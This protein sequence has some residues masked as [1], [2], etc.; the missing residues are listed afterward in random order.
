MC[1]TKKIHFFVLYT[2]PAQNSDLK[3]S[4]NMN[5]FKQQELVFNFK[6]VIVGIMKPDKIFEK[7]ISGQK[8]PSQ[9]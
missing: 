9:C 8:A 7:M 2:I 3:Q 4:V 6:I 5:L 1:L